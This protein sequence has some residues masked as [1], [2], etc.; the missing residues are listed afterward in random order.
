[1]KNERS[2]LTKRHLLGYAFGDFGECLTF[3][4]IGSF[5]TRYYVNVT[6]VDVGVLSVLT[7][8]WKLW[9]AVS[10][11]MVGIF[12]DRMY[13][14]YKFRDGKFRHWMLRAAPL[15]AVTAFLTFTAPSWADG[16][17]KL[18][19]IFVTYLLYQLSYT[20]FN[21][22]YGSLLTPMS[23]TD[24]ERA[25]L[26][27]AR[28]VGGMLGNMIPIALFPVIIAAFNRNPQLGYSAGITL[29]AVIGLIFCLVSYWFT[30]E[31][32]LPASSQSV[33]SAT[34]ADIR[35]SFTKNRAFLAMSVHGLL[36]GILMAVSQTL[37]T[38]MYADVYG[39]LA[40]MSI[41]NL[42]I[43]PLSIL[44]LL[45]SPALTKRMGMVRL[46]RKSLIFG[47][48][49]YTFL[50]LLHLFMDVNIWLHILLSSLSSSLLSVGNMM[51][52]GLVGEA[53]QHNSKLLGIHIEGTLYSLFN[54]LRR[55]GQAIGASSCIALLGWI[56]YDAVLSNLGLPQGTGTIMGIKIL[57]ILLPAILS[58]G[59]WASFYF[60]WNTSSAP[61]KGLAARS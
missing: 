39:D 50:F 58:V 29:C 15:M 13:D 33:R 31:R 24:E 44:V 40:I 46:I 21:I 27:S 25:K 7:F 42:A 8:V 38:Y 59:S 32:I 23:E 17:G 36:Q 20:L 60:L 34:L 2:T 12:L 55:L 4:I 35:A 16:M 47:A 6:L 22:P 37:G 5:L 45:L 49:M 9:D 41:A 18:V 57:C 52:W 56:G 10:N 14:R 11:P 53:I 1:M 61:S 28:G 51:Q 54:M 48:I 26:S 43:L 3:S 19:V 30:E